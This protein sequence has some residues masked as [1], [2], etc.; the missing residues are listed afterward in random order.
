MPTN[1][2][3]PGD[4]Y[5][6]E[7]AHVIPAL[8][9]KA[10]EAKTRGEKEL[11]VWGTGKPRREFLYSDDAAE[12]CLFLMNLSAKKY[13]SFVTSESMPPLVNIGCGEDR[14]I[15][16]LAELVAAVV[17]FKGKLV[18]DASKPDGTPRKLQDTARLNALG[19]RPRIGLHG[20]VGLA[21]QDFRQRINVNSGARVTNTISSDH[22]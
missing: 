10:H 22:A 16:E 9:R 13:G 4:N 11:I 19:W 5:D 20:G 7:T 12:A 15:R 17:G 2:Y 18:F 6:L 1:L 14:S 21:Y 8:I 3:G